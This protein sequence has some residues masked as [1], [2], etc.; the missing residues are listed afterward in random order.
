LSGSGNGVSQG[1]VCRMSRHLAVGTLA[2]AA[3]AV[4]AL[5]FAGGLASSNLAHAQSPQVALTA[6]YSIIGAGAGAQDN[7]TYD[8][9]GMRVTKQA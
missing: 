8:K 3:L 7:L 4:W 5:A 9:S 1:A 6:S 2:L